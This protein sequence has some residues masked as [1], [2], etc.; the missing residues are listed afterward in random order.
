MAHHH[1]TEL[2]QL[3]AIGFTAVLALAVLGLMAGAAWEAH[4][5]KHGR[6]FRSP[7]LEGGVAARFAPAAPA[8]GRVP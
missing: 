6:A 2:Q 3:L 5:R 4:R 1:H 7:V 8:V